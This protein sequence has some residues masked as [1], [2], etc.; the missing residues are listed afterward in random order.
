MDRDPHGWTEEELEELRHVMEDDPSLEEPLMEEYDSG[1]EVDD[2][3]E[4]WD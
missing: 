2:V 1:S 4:V 3:S